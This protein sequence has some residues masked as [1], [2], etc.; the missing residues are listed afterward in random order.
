MRLRHKPH[1]NNPDAGADLRW[2]NNLPVIERL[3]LIKNNQGIAIDLKK[4]R[5]DLRKIRKRVID[6]PNLFHLNDDRRLL[7]E[8]FGEIE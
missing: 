6:C 4:L 3:R 8:A 2:I 5:R 1:W 7:F